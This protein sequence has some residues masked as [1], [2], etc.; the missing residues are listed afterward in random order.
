MG[1][2]S[3]LFTGVKSARKPVLFVSLV[4]MLP[5]CKPE[6]KQESDG[7]AHFYFQEIMTRL[8]HRNILT[9]LNLT[10]IDKTKVVS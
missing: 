4:F 2:F 9:A 10:V 6:E 5:G 3:E 8:T 1:Q 7:D